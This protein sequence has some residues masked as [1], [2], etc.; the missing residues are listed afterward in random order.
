VVIASGNISYAPGGDIAH[1][2]IRKPYAPDHIGKC[3][4]TL[5]R[6]P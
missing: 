2:F 5:L 1:A 4:E 6:S 3:I